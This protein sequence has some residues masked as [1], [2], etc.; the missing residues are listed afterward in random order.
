VL[1]DA[2]ATG[3]S[4][5]PLVWTV[6]DQAYREA[7][8][9]PIDS[10]RFFTSKQAYSAAVD[11]CR[12]QAANETAATACWAEPTE[13]DTIVAIGN[14]INA[15]LMQM[16]T[17]LYQDDNW[18]N[19][20]WNDN[21]L[22]DDEGTS[23]TT[24]A[25]TD[26]TTTP[27]APL[28]APL[29]ITLPSGRWLDDRYEYAFYDDDDFTNRAPGGSGESS[30]D[31][32]YPPFDDDAYPMPFEDAHP[33][34]VGQDNG[35]TSGST[36]SDRSEQTSISAA[37][38]AIYWPSGSGSANDWLKRELYSDDNDWPADDI[39]TYPDY[40]YDAYINGGYLHERDVEVWYTE[41]EIAAQGRN[42]KSSGRSGLDDDIKY[43][44]QGE[45]K[46]GGSTGTTSPPHT[47]VPSRSSTT[48]I[49][50]GTVVAIAGIVTLTLWTVL[51]RS[52][53]RR[54]TYI[55][56][57]SFQNPMFQDESTVVEPPSVAMLHLRYSPFD[58]LLLGDAAVMPSD[59]ENAG[60]NP[61]YPV[62]DDANNAFLQ[63]VHV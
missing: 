40:Y 14:A 12:R 20:M 47:L 23:T 16:L 21:L 43:Y 28:P 51:N 50:A 7:N 15:T 49:V 22:Y 33:Q 18:S 55:T 25:E 30:D 9:T 46:I 37:D 17:D 26:V 61:T 1:Q 38:K 41:D 3:Y 13:L 44:G 36:S 5:D 27:P 4:R 6:V 24:N 59:A 10:V 32:A 2:I 60:H 57:R 34:H 29:G 35:Y 11:E 8:V 39:V 52:S 48:A 31:I 58:H 56:S 53:A 54:A 42:A 62:F 45:E 63:V 19:P